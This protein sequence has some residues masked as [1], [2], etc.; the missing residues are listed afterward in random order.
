MDDPFE[1]EAIN[2]RI[3]VSGA[4]DHSHVGVLVE[5]GDLFAG[6]LLTPP[7]AKELARV[8]LE[9]SGLSEISDT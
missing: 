9:R 1:V 6:V 4:P 2:G 5:R 7:Q 3:Q 8:L